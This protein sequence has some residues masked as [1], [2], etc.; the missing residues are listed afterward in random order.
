MWLR[1]RVR[2]LEVRLASLLFE[3]SMSLAGCPCRG[4]NQVTI[5]LGWSAGG[6]LDTGTKWG[7]DKLHALHQLFTTGP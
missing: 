6:S 4:E 2:E 3:S 5:Q 7:I 1:Q